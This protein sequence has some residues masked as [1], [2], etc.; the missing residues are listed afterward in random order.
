M[1][2]SHVKITKIEPVHTDDRGVIIDILNKPISHV[3]YITFTK[4][5]VRAKHYHTV[6]VQYDYIISGSI[7]LTTCLPDGSDKEENILT[8]GMSS[9]IAPG[10]VH[11]YT[12]L[13]DSVMIDMTTLS[14]DSDGYEK[15]TVRVDLAL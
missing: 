6:S 1:E 8:E 4:G 15:D 10:V 11:M 12:A 2:N 9:E 7:K 3:G 5:A 13:E 14:R